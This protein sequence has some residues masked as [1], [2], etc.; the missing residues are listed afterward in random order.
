MIY[1]EELKGPKSTA[2]GNMIP[3][4]KYLKNCH[5]E[6]ELDFLCVILEGSTRIKGWKF[7]KGRPLDRVEFG[8]PKTKWAA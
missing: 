8:F 2:E 3:A 5:V 6:R 1:E 7:Q 4:F